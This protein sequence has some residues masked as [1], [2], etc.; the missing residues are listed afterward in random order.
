MVAALLRG[1]SKAHQ[2]LQPLFA[3]P[4]GLALLAEGLEAFLGVLRHRRQRDLPF[5]IGEAL[6]ER[7]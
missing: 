6:V 1:L 2:E 7:H 3:R 4:R 5:G